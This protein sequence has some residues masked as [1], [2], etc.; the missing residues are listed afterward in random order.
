MSL[1]YYC[2]SFFDV[3]NNQATYASSYYG[4]RAERVTAKDILDVKMHAKVS[5]TATLLACS[6]LGYMT[7][8]EFNF[9]V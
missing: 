1:H 2:L 5:P 4:M 6:Y 3:R 9:G 8:A 7:E